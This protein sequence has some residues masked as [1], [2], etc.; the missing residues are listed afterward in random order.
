MNRSALKFTPE[1]AGETP[2]IR[3]GL[4]AIKNVGE[5]AMEAAIEER[6]RDGLFKSL[7]DFCARLDSRKV[8]KKVLES[9]V[10]CGAFDWTGIERAALAAEIDSTLAASASSQRDKASGQ[11][12]ALRHL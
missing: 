6:E 10:K 3:Y 5:A 12:G 9:L 8:N 11:A 2:G 1:M 4:A 7:E